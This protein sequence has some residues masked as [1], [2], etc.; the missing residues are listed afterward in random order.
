ML[1]PGS[2]DQPLFYFNYTTHPDRTIWQHVPTEVWPPSVLPHTES[3][4]LGGGL[5]FHVLDQ[6]PEHL[7][8]A[9]LRK[10]VDLTV[11]QLD[12]VIASNGVPLPEKGAAGGNV[13]K[14]DKVTA[15]VNFFF[16]DCTQEFR[17]ELVSQL[18]TTRKKV[19]T[20]ECPDELF[21]FLQ[22]LDSENAGA[23]ERVLEM[24]RD[25]KSE[26]EEKKRKQKKPNPNEKPPT[27]KSGEGEKP[28]PE[29]GEKKASL[30]SKTEPYVAHEGSTKGW[31]YH[32]PPE[33][34]E[35]LPGK[36][37]LEYVYLKHHKTRYQGVYQCY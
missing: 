13:L 16:G 32:T 9:A 19:D 29:T 22:H 18:T 5:V 35:L 4:S 25:L 26:S 24:A 30:V 7:V 20:K 14:K 33:L 17:D 28:N 2:V 21:E 6:R 27:S 1:D 31:S 8:R 34:R 36:H 3:F 15:V 12:Q 11:K 23:F 10:G 37:A